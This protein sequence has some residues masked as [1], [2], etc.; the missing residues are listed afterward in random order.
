VVVEDAIAG[1]EAAKRA[2]MIAVAIGDAQKSSIADAR[3]NDLSE[4]I[5]TIIMYNK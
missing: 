3:I 4:L 2:G 1:I 5:P